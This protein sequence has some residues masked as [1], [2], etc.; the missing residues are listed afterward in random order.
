MSCMNCNSFTL[1]LSRRLI[2]SKNN[3]YSIKVVLW[4][5][6]TAIAV[7]SFALNLIFAIMQGFQSTTEARLQ[8]IHPQIIL[9]SPKGQDFNFEKIKNYLN[10]TPFKNQIQ[11]LTPYALAYGVLHN[12]ELGDQIEF[13]NIS[14][15][16]AIDPN[17]ESLVSKIDSK[18]ANQVSLTQALSDHKIIVGIN[19]A[20]NLGL[21]IGSS[22]QIFIPDSMSAK[23]KAVNFQKI[24][25]VIGNIIKTGVSEFDDSLIITSLN[26]AIKFFP[27]CG[28]CEIGIKLKPDTC[29]LKVLTDLKKHLNLNAFS[30]KDLYTPL[31]AALKLEKYVAVAIAILVILIAIMT[32]IALLFMIMTKHTSTIATLTILGLAQSKVRQLIIMIGLIITGFASM[33]GTLLAACAGLIIQNYPFI[34]LPD[35]YYITTLPIHLSAKDFVGIWISI[36]IIAMFATQIPLKLIRKIN[37]A[38]LLKTND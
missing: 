28:I 26:F 38:T 1:F 13:Y 5:C 24:N 19:L 8:N 22:V 12:P 2:F 7:S 14:L 30:W 34:S 10:Q 32:L 11:A 25:V 31:I 6:V 21:S 37:L 15:I 9:Q 18:L 27:E 35:A 36:L 3:S 23:T 4:V 20:Q 29:E 17:T 33:I 16:K